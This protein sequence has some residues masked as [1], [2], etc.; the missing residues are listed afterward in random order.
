M[1][2]ESG[3]SSGGGGCA[4]EGRRRGGQLDARGQWRCAADSGTD[5]RG[6]GDG[7]SRQ[8]RCPAD[9]GPREGCRGCAVRPAVPTTAHRT[10]HEPRALR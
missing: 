3:V 7:G 2:D 6:T 4:V 1:R 5:G 10:A 9:T 8:G